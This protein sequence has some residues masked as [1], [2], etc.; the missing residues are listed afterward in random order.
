M[1]HAA[2][3][4]W[5]LMLGAC[6]RASPDVGL[7]IREPANRSAFASVDQLALRADRDGRTIAQAT[8]PPTASYVSLASVPFGADTIFTLDGLD[9]TG[10]TIAHGS[11]CPIDF[12]N[13]SQSV[14]LYFAPSDLFAATPGAPLA[15][16]AHQMAVMMNTGDVLFAGGEASGVAVADTFRYSETTASFVAAPEVQL[17][18]PRAGAESSALSI[19]TLLTG[20]TDA[21]GVPLG[22]AELYVSETGVMMPLENSSLGVRAQHRATVLPTDR[23]LLSGGVDATGK[24]QATSSV[25]VVQ[26]DGSAQVS[27][28]P[29]LQVARAAHAAVV[30]VGTPVLIGGYD[31]NHQPLASIE[32]LSLADDGDILNFSIIAQL[33]FARAEETA[34]LLSDGSILIVGGIGSDGMPRADAEVYNPITLTTRLYSLASARSGHTATALSD[35]RVLIVGGLDA[36]GMPLMLN[37]LFIIDV[38]FVSELPLLQARSGHLAVPLCDGTVLIEGGAADA[39]LYSPASD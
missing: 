32:A 18:T 29:P 35:G 28:G 17:S 10:G 15:V 13:I 39:E 37:E 16:R 21:N 38:G 23:V 3:A 19:G 11:T 34:T 26:S 9:S 7:Q 22:S 20:G 1:R 27:E 8:F 31:E 12:E 14:S 30:A 33:Q 4:C 24:S 5:L 36:Q 6:G 2:L 25:V